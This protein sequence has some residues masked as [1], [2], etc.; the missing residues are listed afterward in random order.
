MEHDEKAPRKR[1]WF[2]RIVGLAA[3]AGAGALWR[4]RQQQRDLDEELWGDPR[5][6]DVPPANPEGSEKSD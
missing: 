1:R 3:I 5:D 4:Q 2:S 6:L